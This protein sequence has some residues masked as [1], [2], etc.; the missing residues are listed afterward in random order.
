VVTLS[1]PIEN[2]FGAIITL[3]GIGLFGIPRR[4]LGSGFV[5]ETQ[6]KKNN[7]RLCPHCVKE[8]DDK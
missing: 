6:N 5:E 2:F 4:I 8:I 7:H 3:L 1:A